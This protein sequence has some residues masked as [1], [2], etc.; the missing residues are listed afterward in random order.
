M[1]ATVV[2]ALLLIAVCVVLVLAGKL[3][4]AMVHRRT[5]LGARNVYAALAVLVVWFAAT[6]MLGDRSNLPWLA[7][8]VV[9]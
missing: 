6:V 5:L 8:A 2:H 1:I 7:I 9:M 4:V 3:V